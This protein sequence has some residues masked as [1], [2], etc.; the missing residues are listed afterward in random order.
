MGDLLGSYLERQRLTGA[1]DEVFAPDGSPRPAYR[2]VVA[3]LEALSMPDLSARG[4][5][6][7]SAFTDAGVTFSLSGE[8]RPFP[9]DVVPRLFTTEE[10]DLIERGVAQRVRALEAFLADVYGEGRAFRE[11]VLPRRLI[12]TSAHF[13]RA[14]FGIESANGVRVHVAGIDLVRDAGRR[15]SGARGQPA[16][17]VR[18]ELR[19]GEPAHDGACAARPF[20]G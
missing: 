20:R 5:A 1:Y 17:A 7:S 11:G 6:L 9:L 14:A 15:P 18:R 4:H 8:E 13:H 19:P 2:S 3:G 16:D 12:T 10:W